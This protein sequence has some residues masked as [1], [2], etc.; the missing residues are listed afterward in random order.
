MRGWFER[1]SK[2]VL[3]I[4]QTEAY[5][6][7]VASGTSLK[8]IAFSVVFHSVNSIIKPLCTVVD[9]VVRSMGHSISGNRK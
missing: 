8:C 6:L 2:N 5:L 4:N 3:Y 7:I 9:S 1:G